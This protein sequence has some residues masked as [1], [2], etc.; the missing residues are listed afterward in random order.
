MPGMQDN[1]DDDIL[2]IIFSIFLGN[3]DYSKIEE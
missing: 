3:Q 1:H 2:K